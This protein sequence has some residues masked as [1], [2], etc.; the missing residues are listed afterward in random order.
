MT[1]NCSIVELKAISD[2]DSLHLWRTIGCY[3]CL[4]LAVVH[5]ILGDCGIIVTEN[6]S[7]LCCVLD[8]FVLSYISLCVLTENDSVRHERTSEGILAQH[9]QYPCR[10]FELGSIGSEA[11]VLKYGF[12]TLRIILT[13]YMMHFSLAIEEIQR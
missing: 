9:V 8:L 3:E 7:V 11:F 10:V 12:G 5:S 13:Q 6:G 4:D 1:L 2:K